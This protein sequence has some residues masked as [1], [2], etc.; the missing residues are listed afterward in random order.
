MSEVTPPP[1]YKEYDAYE[2]TDKPRNIVKQW[3]DKVT[4]FSSE[5]DQNR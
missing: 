4:R 1:S 3:V 2:R 5:Y